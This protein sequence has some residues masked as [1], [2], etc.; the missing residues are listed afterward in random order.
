M[1]IVLNADKTRTRH[2]MGWNTV[3]LHIKP[4]NTTK[5]PVQIKKKVCD[6]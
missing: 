6:A 1:V 4:D 3:D 5:H 2:K